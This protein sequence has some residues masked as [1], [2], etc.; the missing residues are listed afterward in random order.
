M[1]SRGEIT[2]TSAT[3]GSEA[4]TCLM[5]LGKVRSSPRPVVREMVFRGAVLCPGTLAGAAAAATVCW[6]TADPTDKQARNPAT[7]AAADS[8]I[9]KDFLD[10]FV[11]AK[12]FNNRPGGW[13]CF[14]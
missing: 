7:N 3:L 13:G 12:Y 1:T 10:V 5:S 2:T 4:A 8:L 14:L 6:A 9:M 11:A